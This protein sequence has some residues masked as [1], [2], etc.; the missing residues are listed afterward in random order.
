MIIKSD[1]LAELIE[2][3]NEDDPLVVTPEPNLDELKTQGSASLDL[4]LGTWFATLRQS[5]TAVLDVGIE[6]DAL[7]E[8]RLTRRYYVPFG[9][10]FYLH[11]HHFVLGVTLEWIRIPSTIA[12]YVVGKSSWG[13]RGLV[14]ATAVGVHPGFSGCLT[15]ELTNLGEIP[16]AIRPGMQICQLFLHQMACE[17]RKHVDSSGF[18]GRRRPILGKV[19]MDDFARRLSNSGAS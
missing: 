2:A 6:G 11:P 13:R 8:S 19:G 9:Q 5:R 4:R 14:I 10:V 3:R 12:G 15:L 1:K 18:V 16:I 7:A 17:D